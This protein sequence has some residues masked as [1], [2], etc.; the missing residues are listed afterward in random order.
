M[1]DP[2][3]I[4]LPFG[5]HVE[6]PASGSRKHVA[7]QTGNSGERRAPVLV[8]FDLQAYRYWLALGRVIYLF[9]DLNP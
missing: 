4:A 2:L 7:G 9:D 8:P 1:G 3:Q 5:E 6:V